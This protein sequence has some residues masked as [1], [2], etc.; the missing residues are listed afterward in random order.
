MIETIKTKI[1]HEMGCQG[2]LKRKEDS[3]F[4]KLFIRDLLYSY[5]FLEFY[6]NHYKYVILA[7]QYRVVLMAV[8]YAFVPHL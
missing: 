2:D 3:A 5:E 8:V 4:V 7:I 6:H 1:I